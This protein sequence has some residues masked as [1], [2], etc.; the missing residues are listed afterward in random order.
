MHTSM[1]T[2][3]INAYTCVHIMCKQ[4][5]FM[6]ACGN[7]GVGDKFSTALARRFARGAGQE[8]VH[9]ELPDVARLETRLE[10]LASAG[11]S[12]ESGSSKA[13][14]VCG[15]ADSSAKYDRCA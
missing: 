5:E 8:T 4:Y 10:R 1:H 11:E 14:E 3:Y 13:H 6:R 9:G 2:P 12:V 15:I 7:L